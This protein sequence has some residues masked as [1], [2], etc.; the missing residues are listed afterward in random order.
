MGHTEILRLLRSC[1]S[2]GSWYL[3]RFCALN[4]RAPLTFKHTVVFFALCIFPNCMK[5]VSYW[6][7][8]ANYSSYCVCEAHP[9][10]VFRHS[11]IFIHCLVWRYWTFPNLLLMFLLINIYTVSSSFFFISL[12]QIVQRTFLSPM[13][14]YMCFP[15]AVHLNSGY[16]VNRV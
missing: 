1:L 11:F 6:P 2:L 4:C 12:L 13:N 9:C 14:I 5:L 15:W 3:N 7:Y 10:N 16:T 8:N